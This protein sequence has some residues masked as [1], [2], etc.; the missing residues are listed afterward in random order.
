MITSP[1]FRTAVEVTAPRSVDFRRA[2]YFA[3]N[4]DIRQGFPLTNLRLAESLLEHLDL[5]RAEFRDMKPQP[6]L[7]RA[8]RYR[9]T[10]NA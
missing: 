7:E 9:N 1:L 3:S 5:A 6:S 10:L 8:F 2:W 4:R